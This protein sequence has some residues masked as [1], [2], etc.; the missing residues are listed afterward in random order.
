MRLDH[1]ARAVSAALE[2]EGEIRSDT[3]PLHRLVAAMLKTGEIHV[4]RDPTRGGLGT[5]LCEIAA[6]SGVGVEI[7]DC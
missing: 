3:Q 6:S 5:S 4:L 7:D 1:A 2:I